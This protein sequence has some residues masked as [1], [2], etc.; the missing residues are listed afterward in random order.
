MITEKKRYIQIQKAGP[1]I[2]IGK[3]PEE[4]NGVIYTVSDK[5]FTDLVKIDP[6]EWNRVLSGENSGDKWIIITIC[7]VLLICTTLSVYFFI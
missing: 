6:S 7:A 4:L 3:R 1:R 5:L 2:F